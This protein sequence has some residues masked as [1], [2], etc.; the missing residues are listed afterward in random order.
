MKNRKSIIAFI[1]LLLLIGV[2][3]GITLY[4][5]I[6]SYMQVS[7]QDDLKVSGMVNTLNRVQDQINTLETEYRTKTE[8]ILELM[9]I[10]LRPYV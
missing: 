5:N 4:S 3:M 1:L 6:L 2:F 8:N 10:A 9:S 7:S